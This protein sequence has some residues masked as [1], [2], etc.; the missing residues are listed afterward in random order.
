M[1][2]GKAVT[3]GVKRLSTAEIAGL[4]ETLSILKDL[5][6]AYVMDSAMRV[7]RKGEGSRIPSPWVVA[8]PPPFVI[9]RA[10]P[11]LSFGYRRPCPSGFLLSPGPQHR[12]LTEREGA[13]AELG[14]MG[15]GEGVMSDEQG[16][17][18]EGEG[19]V[20]DTGPTLRE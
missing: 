15:E 16:E 11:L 19:G 8:F 18:V 13:V 12:K 17:E 3:H 10:S 20:G 6:E 5:K 14:A 1:R 9:V 2:V 4:K 7:L